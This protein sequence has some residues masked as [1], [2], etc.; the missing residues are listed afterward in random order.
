MERRASQNAQAG[1]VDSA[2]FWN[3]IARAIQR[4]EHIDVEAA[5][6]VVRGTLLKYII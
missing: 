6:S 2:A 5:Q 1:D 4:L 3:R